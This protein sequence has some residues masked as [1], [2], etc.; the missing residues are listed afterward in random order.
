M[1]KSTTLVRTMKKRSRGI[2]K[3]LFQSVQ[4]Q[5]LTTT[6][7]MSYQVGP[8]PLPE[9]SG[10]DASARLVSVRHV[11]DCRT[12]SLKKQL[13]ASVSVHQTGRSAGIW[14]LNVC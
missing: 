13:F 8:G 2:P 10:S 9:T 5:A 7:N 12:L 3:P 4:F 11:F 1:R 14:H 6:S